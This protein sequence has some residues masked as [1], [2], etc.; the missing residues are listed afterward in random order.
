GPVWVAVGGGA[1]VGVG[2]ACG[3][4]GG[5]AAG[6]GGAGPGGGGAV[7]AGGGGAGGGAV[8]PAG[9]DAPRRRASTHTSHPFEQRTCAHSPRCSRSIT[10]RPESRVAAGAVEPSGPAQAGSPS[11]G[12][13]WVCLYSAMPL[14]SRRGAQRTHAGAPAHRSAMHSAARSGPAEA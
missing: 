6:A 1:V 5:V 11:F 3:G 8:A 2:A 12:T 14:P 10:S 4:G 9:P 13:T 7:A